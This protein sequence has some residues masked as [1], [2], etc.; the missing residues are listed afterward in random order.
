LY[1]YISSTTKGLWIENLN[2]FQKKNRK[3]TANDTRIKA[4]LARW[5]F[6][7]EKYSPLKPDDMVNSEFPHVVNRK[8]P[9]KRK[10]SKEK[11]RKLKDFLQLYTT[12][13]LPTFK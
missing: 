7:K 13:D 6:S 4:V 1:E 8:N 12:V 9:T 3:R 5:K 11:R 2:N 10:E